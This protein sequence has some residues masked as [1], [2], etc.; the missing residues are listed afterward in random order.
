MPN[1]HPANGFDAV[2]LCLFTGAAYASST[3]CK[4]NDVNIVDI[5]LRI[6]KQCGMYS[7]EYK[8]WIACK[9]I[10]PAIPKMFDTF[11]AFWAAK[12]TLVNQTAIPASLHGYEMAAINDNNDALVVLYGKSI[13]NFGVVYAATQ[14]SIKTQGSTMATLQ[15][16]V[17]AMQQY[18]MAIQ[19]QPPLTIHAA[20]QQCGPNNRRRSSPRNG[21]GGNDYQQQQQQSNGMQA[22]L[23][24]PT[25][26]KWYKNWHYCST[27]GGDVNDNHT[28]ATCAKPGP[29]HNPQATC[30]NT[31]GRLTAGMHKTILP[32]ALGRAPPVAH[33]PMQR[34]A[35]QAAWQNMPPPNFAAMMAPVGM[36]PP[37]PMYQPQ[38]QMNYMGQLPQQQMTY[39]GHQPAPPPAPA[40][41]APPP[42][43]MVPYYNPYQQF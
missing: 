33:A 26:F 31:M 20:Q 42:G 22:P 40:A 32:S 19:Q 43:G 21:R 36:C 29:M 30:T 41:M 9:S 38:Q 2:I 35:F 11:K 27:H 4:M 7:K 10:C 18:C 12:I 1:W 25:P 8:A 17:N 39:M 28:S 6:I 34:P 16:Q 24:P 5:G 37:I 13:T 3:G 23:R 15:G 14:E